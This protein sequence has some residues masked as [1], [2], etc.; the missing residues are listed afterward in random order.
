MA[1]CVVAYP[2]AINI[3]LKWTRLRD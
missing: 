3:C 2:I 1:H